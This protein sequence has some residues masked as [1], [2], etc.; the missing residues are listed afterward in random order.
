MQGLPVPIVLLEYAV[1]FVRLCTTFVHS[2]CVWIDRLRCGSGRFG[3]I[4]RAYSDARY[5]L[6][7]V[8][9]NHNFICDFSRLHFNLIDFSVNRCCLPL[10]YGLHFRFSPQHGLPRHLHFLITSLCGKTLSCMAIHKFP[11]GSQQL[12]ARRQTSETIL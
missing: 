8:G 7:L 11:T 10:P 9:I 4:I 3:G 12:T 1:L 2:K 6:S 5:L